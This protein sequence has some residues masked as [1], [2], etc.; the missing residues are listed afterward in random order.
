MPL[1]KCR[2]CGQEGEAYPGKGNLCKNCDNSS[3]LTRSFNLKFRRKSQINAARRISAM[4]K[5]GKQLSRWI[6]KDCRNHDKKAGLTCDLSRQDIDE[7]VS[8]PC[9][10]CGETHIR[11]TLDRIDNSQGHT[12]I[13]VVGAC[14]R[15]NLLRKHMPIEA[16]REVSIG[17]RS[18]REKG[19]FGDWT[20]RIR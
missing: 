14:I 20:G 12:R 18:A 15:C 5:A 7:I 10:W 9:E 6:L 2:K 17:V 19:L 13:N 16:W 3:R 1:V 11:M 4:R 8:K